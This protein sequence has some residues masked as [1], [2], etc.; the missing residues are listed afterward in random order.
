MTF[1]EAAGVDETPG[2][3]AERELRAVLSLR[4]LR[5]IAEADDPATRSRWSAR[6]D[7]AAAW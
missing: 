7:E 5:A 6:M 2:G 1:C 4:L 3:V